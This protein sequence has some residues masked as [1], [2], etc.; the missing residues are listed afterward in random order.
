MPSLTKPVFAHCHLKKRGIDMTAENQPYDTP[1]VSTLGEAELA[2]MIPAAAAGFERLST[3]SVDHP[4]LG[5]KEVVAAFSGPS[6][7]SVAIS[8]A[9]LRNQPQLY[10]NFLSGGGLRQSSIGNSFGLAFRQASLQGSP[11][12]GLV[13]GQ[14]SPTSLGQVAGVVGMAR[15]SQAVQF[16]L[17][18]SPQFSPQASPQGSPQFSPQASPQG[19]PQASPQFSPQASPQ[20]SPQ[21]SPQ[22]SPQF[23][24]QASPQASPQFSPQA[25]PQ[26]SPQFSPQ[27]SPQ[28]SP[29][30]SPQFSPQGSP[31]FSPQFSPQG[32][33][34][35]SPQ[36]SPQASPQFSPQASPQF[37]PQ[38]SPQ[39]SP[40]AS[41]QF[42]PQASPTQVV[43][44]QAS[45]GERPV[46]AAGSGNIAPSQV[47]DRL[48]RMGIDLDRLSQIS[49]ESPFSLSQASSP[50]D[51]S[52]IRPFGIDTGHDVA[53]WELYDGRTHNGTLLLGVNDRLGILIEA[54]NVFPNTLLDIASNFD[55]RQ[56]DLALSADA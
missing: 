2:R 52:Y 36:F 24:P 40:Q 43:I 6:G 29:Q 31:Q 49:Q 42:S 54:T 9:D 19:S 48:Q 55:F 4:D 32:S 10:R 50:A 25:S 13:L 53:G 46:V 18:D 1:A 39:F 14:A 15:T 8:I 23:S 12:W 26:A 35:A 3:T 11:N 38:A 5:T 16:L 7:S 33:P 28:F 51:G 21:E 20:F 47:S 34:Q 44:S 30:A 45:P 27:A 22:A 41:P 56:I 37:S 17:Q